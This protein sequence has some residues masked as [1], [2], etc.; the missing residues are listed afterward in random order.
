MI[1]AYTSPAS[2]LMFCTSSGK[3][4]NHFGVSVAVTLYVEMMLTVKAS[5]TPFDPHY[6]QSVSNVDQG[7][8]AKSTLQ[9]GPEGG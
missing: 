6:D 9:T 7:R 2:N 5:G 8:T 4:E 3:S 1:D